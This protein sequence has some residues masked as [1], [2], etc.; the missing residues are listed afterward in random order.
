MTFFFFRKVNFSDDVYFFRK[1]NFFDD[2][3]FGKET[4]FDDF[5]LEKKSFLMTVFFRKE[6]FFVVIW[7]AGYTRTPKIGSL[8]KSRENQGLRRNRTDLNYPQRH[9]RQR[10]QKGQGFTKR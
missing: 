5:F 1:E 2:V 4:F 6:N 10:V 8:K 3:F 7:V 9:V